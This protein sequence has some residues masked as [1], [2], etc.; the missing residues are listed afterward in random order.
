M[1]SLKINAYQIANK[2][3]LLERKQLIK[4]L[5]LFRKKVIFQFDSAGDGAKASWNNKDMLD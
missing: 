2:I 3:S 1:K 5:A 4:I